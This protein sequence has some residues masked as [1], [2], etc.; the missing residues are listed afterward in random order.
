[1]AQLSTIEGIGPA[2]AEKLKSAGVGSIATLLA[3]CSTKAG[4]KEIAQKTGI[5]EKRLLRFVNHADLMRIKGIGG[6]YA[7]LL[8]A[9]G[10]DTVPELARRKPENLLDS[11][12]KANSE[13]KRVRNIATRDQI[14]E[15]VR[16]AGT[17]GRQIEY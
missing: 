16:Q 10:V 12:R 7:E 4:R 8:E 9:A 15:W 14:A 11:M 5:D 1:M 2:Y 3:H 17:L 6:Q 13:H